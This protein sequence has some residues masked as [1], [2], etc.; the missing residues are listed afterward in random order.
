MGQ[1]YESQVM[2]HA[3]LDSG[4]EGARKSQDDPQK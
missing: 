1:N 4:I 3:D 2:T